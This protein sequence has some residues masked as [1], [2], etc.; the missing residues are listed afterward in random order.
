MAKFIKT[1]RRERKCKDGKNFKIGKT[2]NKVK[3]QCKQG[4]RNDFSN[5]EMPVGKYGTLWSPIRNKWVLPNKQNGLTVEVLAV[6]TKNLDE[7]NVSKILKYFWICAK[8]SRN[9]NTTESD[10][11]SVADV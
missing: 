3:W 11:S 4:K 9:A 7:T 5:R 2:E 1:K 10:I 8:S 6:V